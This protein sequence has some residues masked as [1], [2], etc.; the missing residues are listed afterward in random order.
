MKDLLRA[1]FILALFAFIGLA[2]SKSLLPFPC[3]TQINNYLQKDPAVNAFYQSFSQDT[4]VIKTYKDS[5]WDI[6]LLRFAG[7][8]ETVAGSMAEKFWLLTIPTIQHF[9]IPGLAKRFISLFA[10]KMP[11]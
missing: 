3:D 1:V 5:L 4:I 6:S 11:Q 7:S 10:L 8:C 2:T 9:L